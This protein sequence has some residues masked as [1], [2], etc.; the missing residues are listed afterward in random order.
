M[1]G[2]REMAA[3]GF[4]RRASGGLKLARF[5][6]ITTSH[7][8]RRHVR[9][10]LPELEQGPAARVAGEHGAGD[11]KIAGPILFPG[12]SSRDTAKTQSPA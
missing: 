1:G 5:V 8:P 6:R 10:A 12:L 2:V 7:P 11:Q 4:Y 3:A 9:R